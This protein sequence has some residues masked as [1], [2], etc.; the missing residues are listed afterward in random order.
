MPQG[1]KRPGAGRKS[2]AEEMGLK[3]LLD[4]CFSAKER[5]GVIRKLVKDA[6]DFNPQVR[7][8][9]RKL[10]MAYTFGQPKAVTELTGKDGGPVETVSKV[11]KIELT[12]D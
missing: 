1:G 2:K 12:D 4:K 6:S 8:A 9:A 11:Y 10:L 3:A 7:D 5:E